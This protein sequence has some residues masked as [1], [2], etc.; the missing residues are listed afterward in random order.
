MRTDEQRRLPTRSVSKKFEGG[1]SIVLPEGQDVNDVY[2][3]GG[4]Q[5]VLSLLWVSE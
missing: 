3:R 4:R 5:A 1:I 2:L